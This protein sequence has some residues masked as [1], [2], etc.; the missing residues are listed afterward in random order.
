MTEKQILLDHLVL[1][2]KAVLDQYKVTLRTTDLDFSDPEAGNWESGDNTRI[3]A[4]MRPSRKVTGSNVYYYSRNDMQAAFAAIG[5][6]EVPCAVEGTP[7]IGKVLS[8]LARR[9]NFQFDPNHVLDA[10]QVDDQFSF[11][12]SSKCLLW[13]GTLTVKIVDGYGI[14]LDVAFPNNVLDGFVPPEFVG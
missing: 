2:N 12:V 13:L 5:F 4:T 8:E 11:G 9:Y 6:E 1:K 14:P 3:I 10:Q 7:D